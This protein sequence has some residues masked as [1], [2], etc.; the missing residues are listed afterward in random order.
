MK[1]SNKGK[2]VASIVVLL[3]VLYWFIFVYIPD[4]LCLFAFTNGKNILTGEIKTFRSS[5]MPIGWKPLP[6]D[7]SSYRL[8]PK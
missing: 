6:W 7:D 1:T 5:C 3:G 4:G 8:K 2:I